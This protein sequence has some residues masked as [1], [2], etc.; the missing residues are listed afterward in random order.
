MPRPDFYAPPI[1]AVRP[2]VVLASDLARRTGPRDLALSAEEAER[3]D[4]RDEERAQRDNR[5][6]AESVARHG[7][8]S[9]VPA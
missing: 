1:T 9:V 3:A 6:A 4:R 2:P 7:A 5:R 8:M